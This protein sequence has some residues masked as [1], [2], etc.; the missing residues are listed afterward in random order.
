MNPE[1]D[2]NRKHDIY[3]LLEIMRIL[4]S[5]DGC[6]WDKVQT[7]ES[8]RQDCLEEACEVCEAID[9]GD[10]DELKE[11][12]GDLLLQVVFHTVIEEELNHFTFE[13]VCDGISS[14]LIHR[15]PHVFKDRDK[16][17]GEEKQ[18][19]WET[20]KRAEHGQK[21][22]T[23]A[24]DGVAHTLPSIWRMSKMIKKARKAGYEHFC[25]L[26][27]ASESLISAVADQDIDN[28]ESAFSIFMFSIINELYDK[29]DLERCLQDSCDEF[30]N[31]FKEWEES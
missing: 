2:L 8:I 6:P 11:E 1:F 18:D 10:C 23:E 12:L 19:M 9:K 30:I 17:A 25:K 29:I 20:A 14:K 3:D 16:Y 24:L 22:T 5:E 13:D 31:Q 15:H 21:N 26:P 28:V 4:R 27:Q 7:H